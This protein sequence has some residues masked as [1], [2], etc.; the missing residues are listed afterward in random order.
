VEI[1]ANLLLE[2]NTNFVTQV[3]KY[4]SEIV[5]CITNACKTAIPYAAR[6]TSVSDH[7]VP[8]WNDVVD[9]KHQAARAASLDS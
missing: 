5:M 4:Y 3:N 8:G 1:P 9:D 6:E 7:C 2:D